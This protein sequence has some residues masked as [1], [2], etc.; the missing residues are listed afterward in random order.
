MIILPYEAVKRRLLLRGT[1]PFRKGRG[2]KLAPLIGANDARRN[3]HSIAARQNT[4]E[5]NRQPGGARKRI[6]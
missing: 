1:P 3:A 2:F 4:S 6:R 5:R